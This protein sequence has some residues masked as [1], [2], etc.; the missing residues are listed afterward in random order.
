[1]V[2]RRGRA[3]RCVFCKQD[4][5][6]SKSVEHIIPESLGNKEHT[7][8][9]GVVCDKCNNYFAREVEKPFL[10]HSAIEL[11]RFEEGVENKK[12][13]IPPTKG[14]IFPDAPVEVRKTF[15][16]GIAGEIRVP[17]EYFNKIANLKSGQFI[18]PKFTDELSLPNG[19]ILSRFIGK[20]AI[21]AF[22]QRLQYNSK[23]V[24]EFIDDIQLDPLRNH[25]R[26]GKEKTWDCNVR[27]IYKSTNNWRDGSTTEIYQITNEYDFLATE[28]NEWYFVIALFGIEFAIN[29]GGI[30]IDGYKKWLMEHDNASPLHFGKN[31]KLHK[32]I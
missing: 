29:I 7:L 15:K 11:L 18:I 13:K 9:S 28:E 8:P 4:S 20:I 25:V 6:E 16:D 3:V 10:E 12:G 23:L 30:S 31:E 22:A 26:L 27:R 32:S 2:G 21:E 14:V 24:E 5:K 19:S 1:M 17:T